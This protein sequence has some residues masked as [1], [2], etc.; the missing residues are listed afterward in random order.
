MSDDLTGHGP[1]DPVMHDYVKAM[2]RNDRLMGYVHWGQ[3]G[4]VALYRQLVLE[5]GEEM[6]WSVTYPGLGLD[7]CS[8]AY[9]RSRRGPV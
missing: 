6:V 5:N 3:S 1:I 4:G 8:L 7:R 9:F 2:I